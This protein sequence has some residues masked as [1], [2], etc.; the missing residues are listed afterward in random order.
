MAEEPF[1]SISIPT[2]N[3]ASK[4]DRQL[5]WLADELDDVDASV[6][7]TVHDNHSTDDTPA[8]C[9]RW[10]E[11]IPNLQVH[12]N[13]ENIGLQPN[14]CTALRSATGQWCW[15]VSD[16]DDLRP[17]LVADVIAL[18]EANP[19]LSEL[20]LNHRGIDEHGDVVVEQFIDAS[21]TGR[22]ENGMAG[23]GHHLAISFNSLLL[24]TAVI[25]RTEFA[26]EAIDAWTGT[27]DNWGIFGFITG[28]VA[29]RGP[30][31]FTPG[32]E[33]DALDGV[34]AWFSES[35]RWT[36]MLYYEL[37]ATAL[38]LAHLGYPAEVCRDVGIRELERQG[39]WRPRA[40]L[41]AL[42]ACPRSV[43]TVPRVLALPH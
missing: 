10:R 19:D 37:P 43:F 5:A 26:W 16:D 1:L 8:V 2:F 38:A 23:W 24:M 14:L 31:Y 25:L 29:M 17:G 7:V 12:R 20:Y 4:L 34:S 30:I 42:R 11:R 13:A 18:L 9:E 36:R 28:H 35:G 32:V 41:R 39:W 27:P 22:V 40:H 6:V 15:A 33:I 3:R 21:L